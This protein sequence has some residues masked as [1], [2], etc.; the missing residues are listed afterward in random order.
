MGDYMHELTWL[1]IIVQSHLVAHA[2]SV[3]C[4]C[5]PMVGTFDR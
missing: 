2:P 3:T 4:G 1:C 5:L